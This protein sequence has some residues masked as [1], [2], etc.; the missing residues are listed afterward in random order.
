MGVL[1][2]SLTSRGALAKWLPPISEPLRSPLGRHS[3][4]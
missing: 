1:V 3:G 2:L 4:K